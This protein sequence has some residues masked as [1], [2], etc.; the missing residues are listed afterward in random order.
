MGAR[1]I[2]HALLAATTFAPSATLPS[3]DTPSGSLLSATAAAPV[4]LPF[5][6]Q[7]V[8]GISSVVPEGDDRYL[9]LVDNGYGTLTN[10]AD[11]ELR[12]Y[13]MRPSFRGSPGGT[14]TVQIEAVIPLQDPD[15]QLPFTITHEFTADRR[16]TGAD[17]DPESMVRAPD[18]TLWLGDEFGPYLL[19]VGSDGRI[20]EPPIEL[21]DVSAA[22]SHRTPLVSLQNPSLEE[23]A[24]LRVLNALYAHGQAASQKTAKSAPRPVVSPAHELLKDGNPA[25]H[26]A[27]RESRLP[28][29]PPPASRA[30]FDVQQLHA[31]GYQ[32][33][34][35]TV[36]DPAR[37]RELMALGV[38]GL[39]SDRPDLLMT[40]ALQF[41]GNRDGRAD[42]VDAQGRLDPQRFDVQGHRGARGLRPENTLPAF[43]VALDLGVSTLELD[44]GITAD[45]VPMVSHDPYFTPE[46][47]LIDGP[48]RSGLQKF[49]DR[50]HRA[51]E[52]KGAVLI[53]AYRSDWLQQHV[54]C[55]H[56][57]R[58]EQQ[59]DPAL[60]PVTRA[61]AEAQGLPNPYTPPTL[62]QVLAFARFYQHYYQ[63]G[64]GQTHPQAPLRAATADRVRFNVETKRHPRHERDSFHQR[65]VDRTVDAR[66]FALAVGAVAS[67]DNMSSRVDV[68]SFDF[69]TLLPLQ[70]TYPGLRPI[71]LFADY[72]VVPFIAGADGANLFPQG[73]KSPWLAGASWPYRQ[74]L[75]TITARV[76]T[77]GGLEAM[78]L[79]PDGR[80]LYLMLEKPL[81]PVATARN[82]T[83]SP[84]SQTPGATGNSLP[85]STN[86]HDS[87]DKHS[88]APTPSTS[89]NVL[90]LHRFDL[91][92]HEF[93]GKPTDYPLSPEAK[94]VPD[95]AVLD[96]HTLLV[97]ERDD[98]EGK[99]DGWK[100]IFRVTLTGPGNIP[101]KTPY[102][103]LMAL[104]DP[105]FLAPAQPGDVGVGLQPDG[106]RTPA[107]AF[108]YI[109]PETLVPLGNNRLLIIN[110]NNFP[111]SRGRHL[112]SH[113]A[114][115]TEWIVVEVSP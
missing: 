51:P 85:P 30:L 61:F 18:G 8:Q 76:Q 90:E 35:W 57:I 50:L 17:L 23:N 12:L 44:T 97:V 33:V 70:E 98:S 68:Q 86:G 93:V 89:A 71:L 1:L 24:A 11:F 5:P 29:L 67:A 96:E 95:L 7:P 113:A 15:H 40:E 13:R 22:H 111:F 56:K 28:I 48:E 42:F 110:D 114:D 59:N 82:S 73:K 108:P 107:Y 115:D 62:A 39:I 49:S 65:F 37:M 43:E 100:R 75:Q 20:L 104:T 34:P 3:P 31:A 101:I 16:L 74:T 47:C 81:V 92:T 84:P 78:G 26:F 55:D 88:A 72:P 112:G 10:S 27:A 80:T 6:G 14:G 9:V 21:P 77:S 103:D 64:P 63:S 25:I 91:R 94:S 2:G 87:F 4:A 45:G 109:T 32:V 60:S 52:S 38:D 41:D 53:K 106:S 66:T 83:T 99:L 36:N 46:K 19:H 54:V 58:P 79:S 102:L 105:D 69:N